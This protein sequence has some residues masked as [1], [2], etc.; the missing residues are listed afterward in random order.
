LKILAKNIIG[1][2][3][4]TLSLVVSNSTNRSI[5]KERSHA[6]EKNRYD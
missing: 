2:S 6:S 3:Q 4:V 5:W 1:V